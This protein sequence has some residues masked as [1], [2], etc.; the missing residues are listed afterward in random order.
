MQTIL[1]QLPQN[2]ERYCLALFVEE[3]SVMPRG[4]VSYLRSQHCKC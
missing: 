4:Y 3:G 2:T 1:F